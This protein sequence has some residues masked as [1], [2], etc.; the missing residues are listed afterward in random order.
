MFGINRRVDRGVALLDQRKPG[1]E[2]EVNLSRLNIASSRWC[3]LG[4][5]YRHNSHPFYRSGYG[6][7]LFAL[8]IT[9][10]AWYGFMYKSFL[11]FPLEALLLNFRW[12]RVIQS[13]RKEAARRKAEAEALI[14]AEAEAVAEA[15]RICQE[16]KEKETDDRVDHTRVNA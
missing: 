16:R 4:Q 7:G 15:I 6:K 13:R 5:L 1:W 9:D 3:V 10:S 12:R 14:R 8:H 11:L 2:D